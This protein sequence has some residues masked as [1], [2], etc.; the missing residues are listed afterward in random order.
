MGAGLLTLSYIN[1]AM[2]TGAKDFCYNNTFIHSGIKTL[3]VFQIACICAYACA[4]LEFP[5]VPATSSRTQVQ[6]SWSEQEDDP[7]SKYVITMEVFS[8]VKGFYLPTGSF[9]KNSLKP[10]IKNKKNV[11]D[12]V[13]FQ[14][15]PFLISIFRE[16]TP[17]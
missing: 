17:L 7:P 3:A 11:S 14:S 9:I 12:E 16:G 2:H 5:A 15:R 8:A 6:F 1:T 4:S 13:E 10:L